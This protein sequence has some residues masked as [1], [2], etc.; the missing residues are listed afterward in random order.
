MPMNRIALI[1]LAAGLL[2]G[3]GAVA[4]DRAG[5]AA[6][7]AAAKA[8]ARAADAVGGEWRDTGKLIEQ[9]ERAAADGDFDDAEALANQAEHQ[10]R[11]GREQALSQ[12]GVGNPTYLYQ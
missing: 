7:I 11:L 3:G 10:G 6:A 1:A 8:A 9:A 5:A 4:A 2:I 12:Q